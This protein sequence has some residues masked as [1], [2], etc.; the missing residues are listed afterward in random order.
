MKKKPLVFKALSKPMKYINDGKEE[1]TR[2]DIADSIID[3]L[4]IG[5]RYTIRIV[6]KEYLKKV[7]QSAL[8]K[9]KQNHFDYL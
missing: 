5:Q 2:G 3:S 8:R 6:K 4:S 9:D 7:I 1:L